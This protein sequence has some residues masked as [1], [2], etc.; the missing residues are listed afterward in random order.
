MDFN[1]VYCDTVCSVSRAVM[2]NDPILLKRLVEEKKL[3]S[4]GHDNRGW[5]PIHHAAKIGSVK[6]LD[7][8]TQ[9]RECNVG[10]QSHEGTTYL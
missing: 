3:S 2:I 6:C 9:L 4:S 8:L 7:I 1:E 10:W 5:Y